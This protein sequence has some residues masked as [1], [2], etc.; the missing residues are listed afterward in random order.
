MYICTFFFP[1]GELGGGEKKVPLE[2]YEKVLFFGRL[3]PRL[4]FSLACDRYLHFF[5]FSLFILFYFL[6]EKIKIRGGLF[7]GVC[8]VEMVFIAYVILY[9]HFPLPFLYNYRKVKR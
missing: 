7:R 2:T 1:K 9:L 4:V 6:L 3:R 8:L 5:F